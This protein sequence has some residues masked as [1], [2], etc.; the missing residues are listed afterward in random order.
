MRGSLGFV[1]VLRKVTLRGE[2]GDE[3]WKK[4]AWRHAG[5]FAP[6]EVYEAKKEKRTRQDRTI[7][8][9]RETGTRP[10]EYEELGWGRLLKTGQ[11]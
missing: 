5:I 11:T 1:R 4:K 7:P 2:F 6:T 9:L 3:G 10:E 8:K